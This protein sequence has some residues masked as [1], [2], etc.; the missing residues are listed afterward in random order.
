MGQTAEEPR[1]LKNGKKCRGTQATTNGIKCRGTQATIKGINCRG[2]QAT[3]KWYK[4]QRN[5]GY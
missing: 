1:L 2:T 4:L 3:E 5:P